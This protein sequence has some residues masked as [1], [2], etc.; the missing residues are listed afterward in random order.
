MM[1]VLFDVYELL[2]VFLEIGGIVLLLI[3][4]NIFGMW[5]LIFE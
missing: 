2:W 5:I 3:G 1:Y 4:I